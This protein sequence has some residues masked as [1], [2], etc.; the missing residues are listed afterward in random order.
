MGAVAFKVCECARAR[1][2]LVQVLTPDELLQLYGVYK[3]VHF[4]DA[5]GGGAASACDDGSRSARKWN[6]WR[7]CAGRSR[8]TCM[9]TYVALL[10]KVADRLAA[11]AKAGANSKRNGV[12]GHA[13]R[14]AHVDAHPI[15]GA[16]VDP[17][18]AYRVRI[19][20]IGRHLPSRVVTNAH[21]ES[22]GGFPD[23]SIAQSRAGVHS[24]RRAAPGE[25]ASQMA[26]SAAREALAS[27]GVDAAELDCIINASGSP[28][29]IIPDGGPLLQH[30]LGLGESGIQVRPRIRVASTGVAHRAGVGRGARDGCRPCP[31]SSSRTPFVDGQAG[32]L[33]GAASP[34]APEQTGC[35]YRRLTG[36]LPAAQAFSVHATCLSFLVGLETAC[37]MLA[38]PNSKYHTIL[39]ASSEVTSSGVDP[40]DAHSGALI[41]APPLARWHAALSPP[42][43]CT[44]RT[45][46]RQT[47]VVRRSARLTTSRSL[48]SRALWRR[49]RGGR[50][51]ASLRG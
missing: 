11:T 2:R 37:A 33:A 51:P 3:Q 50:G 26:A 45:C 44:P 24:R 20:G 39:V 5:P 6:S 38:R 21:V 43:P 18:V 19:L 42:R 17:S 23:G 25:T 28:E 48:R 32:F 27:A 1:A 22:R 29:Q 9:E 41:T 16:E 10:D 4:G 49:R 34:E 15:S 36:R 46:R 14:R 31:V 30:E 12:D 13:S 35:S 8:E 7:R 40:F 47:V